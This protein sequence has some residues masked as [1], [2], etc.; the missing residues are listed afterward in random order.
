MIWGCGAIR[1]GCPTTSTDRSV[2]RSHNPITLEICEKR[3]CAACRRQKIVLSESLREA[4]SDTVVTRWSRSG[5][6]SVHMTAQTCLTLSRL[7]QY[8]GGAFLIPYFMFLMATGLP[9]MQAE[10]ALGAC[11]APIFNTCTA[12]VTFFSISDPTA[13]PGIERHLNTAASS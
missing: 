4:V 6:A 13:D 9:L 12:L 5:H 10:L 3:S 11:P 1:S 8:G 2:I 7:L